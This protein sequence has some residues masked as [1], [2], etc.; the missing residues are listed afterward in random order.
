M[1]I[2]I[3]KDV[4]FILLWVILFKVKRTFSS[5]LFSL[6]VSN[7]VIWNKNN[8]F[9]LFKKYGEKNVWWQKIMVGFLFG[10]FVSQKWN[11]QKSWYL[12]Y[13]TKTNSDNLLAIKVKRT[14]MLM[15]KNVYLGLSILELTKIVM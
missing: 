2:C 15:N 7:L 11:Q 12:M 3:L 5:L 13:H 1:Y 14:P 8:Y 6:F 9:F 10:S 4:F